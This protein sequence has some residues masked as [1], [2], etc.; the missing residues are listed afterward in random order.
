VSRSSEDLLPLLRCPATGRRLVERDGALVTDDGVHRYPVARGVPVLIAEERSL[1]DIGPIVDA[2]AGEHT[3]GSLLARLLSLPPT[4]TRNVAGEANM[5]ELVRLLD[6]NG[7]VLVIGGRIEGTGIQK[8][9][10]APGLELVETDVALGPRT[11]LV[12]DAHDLPFADGSF[13]AVV[14]QA[15]LEAVPDVERVAAEVHRVLAPGGI[16]YSEAPFIQQVH[17]GAYD[18][19][20]FTHLGHRRLWRSFDELRS[21]T[22]CGPGMA[23]LWSL[24]YFLRAVAGRRRL[25]RGLVSRT[26][27]LLFFWLKYVDDFLVSRPAGLD[28]ASGTFFLG[29]RRS[30]PL[31]DR[32]IVHAF[33]GVRPRGQRLPRLRGAR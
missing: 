30:Q 5:A 7:R 14:I 26:V 13:D 8:L 19:N 20:R 31:T 1:F 32:E 10:N 2:G 6:G 17:D 23:L 16:V 3:G 11:R 28:A 4:H 33:K 27:T 29:R 25:L 15:V 12:C 18:F 9:L 24:E 22:Q 21:G